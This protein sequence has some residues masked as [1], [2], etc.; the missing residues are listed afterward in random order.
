MN[1]EQIIP[2]NGVYSVNLIVGNKS[3]N[4]VCNIGVCPTLHNR[5]EISVEVHVVD[6]IIDL[7]N[8]NVTIEFIKYIRNEKKFNNQKEL[9]K[10]IEKDIKSIKEERIIGSD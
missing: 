6:K 10:Q 5:D 4:S 1:I 2:S 9:I 8:C 7:Y 3:Y